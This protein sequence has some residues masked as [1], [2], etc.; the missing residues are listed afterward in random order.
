MFEIVILTVAPELDQTEFDL[1]LPLVSKE[2]QERIKRYRFFQDSQNILL[3]DV[4]LRT[5]ICRTTCLRNR[6]LQFSKNEYGKPFL[7]NNSHVHFNISHSG[8][9]VAC[10]LS[11]EPVGIDIEIIRPIDTRIA[12][13]FFTIDEVAYIMKSQQTIR[14]F[15]IW[16][17]KESRIKW[18]GKGLLKLLS[19][20]S[21]LDPSEL[22]I[23]DYYSLFQNN[24][25]IC[26]AC[27][28]TKESPIIRIMDTVT[29]MQ[30][31]KSV[32][33]EAST[34]C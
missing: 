6:N 22:E 3:G 8:N 33:F 7:V 12:E 21:V 4:L 9:Y 32:L 34:F 30:I 1:L 13:R 10:A 28:T 20:F 23:F 16:T 5:E 25:V 14:F 27:S 11:N 31:V 15:E 17:K 29:V 18:E 26:H 24:E 19:S 2:K